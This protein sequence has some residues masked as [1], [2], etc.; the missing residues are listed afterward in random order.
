MSSPHAGDISPPL[1]P[2]AGSAFAAALARLTH[3]PAE[4][5]RLAREA[6]HQATERARRL[7]QWRLLCP[8]ELRAT[9][10]GDPRLAPYLRRIGR[11]RAWRP[12]LGSGRGLYIV[13]RSGRG[14]SRSFWALLREL[15]IE[16]HRVRV[17]KQTELTR[18]LN[19]N[20]GLFLEEM[21]ALHYVPILAWDDF[22]KFAVLDARDEVLKSEIEHLI[23]ARTS[24]GRPTLITTN[25]TRADI[26]REFGPLRAEPILRRLSEAC[27]TVDFGWE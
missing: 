25:L 20:P 7:E 1:P 8:Q 16:G 14:K 5:E 11:V 3:G 13:G 21:D 17:L 15:F 26:E 23:D 10:W 12:Q 6:A 22:G 27:E 19:R 4:A 9:A 18:I 2:P 24:N